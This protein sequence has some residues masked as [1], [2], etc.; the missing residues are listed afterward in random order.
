MPAAAAALG[1]K[2]VAVI[3]GSVFTSSTTGAPS[4][5]TMTSTRA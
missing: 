2:L 3:P 4:A 5:A 1:S